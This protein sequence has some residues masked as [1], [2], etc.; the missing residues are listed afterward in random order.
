[1]KNI[2]AFL[3]CSALFTS[4]V[5]AGL[6]VPGEFNPVLCET[7]FSI[8]NSEY[9]VTK[10]IENKSVSLKVANSSGEQFWLSDALG[11]QEKLFTIDGASTSLSIKDVTGDGIP[12]LITAATTGPETSAL[13]IFKYDAE[14]K[15]FTAM[16]FK[17]EKTDLTRDF[18]VSDMYQKDGQDIVFMPDNRI[19]ALGKIY[20]EETAPIAGFYYFKLTG[21]DFI[22]SEVEPVPVVVTPENK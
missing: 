8:S 14:G 13:Y 21:D 6:A 1:M 7:S 3:L 19:R 12:E 17:Y 16:N 15:K 2:L 5:F 18:M 20:S 11:E 22:C 10:N 9:R 4:P